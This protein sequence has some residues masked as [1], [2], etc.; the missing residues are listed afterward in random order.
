MTTITTDTRRFVN[1]YMPFFDSKSVNWADLNAFFTKNARLFK[2]E[3][4]FSLALYPSSNKRTGEEGEDEGAKEVR[5]LLHF[6]PFVIL[7]D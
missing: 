6:D 2:E 5:F 7:D 3:W 1:R 4:G